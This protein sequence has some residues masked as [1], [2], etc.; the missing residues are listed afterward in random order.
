MAAVQRMIDV[1]VRFG[2]VEVR[3][4]PDEPGV[5]RYELRFPVILRASR[6]DGAPTER[7]TDGES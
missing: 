5:L 4:L 6:A 7:R 1:L 2:P 3:R